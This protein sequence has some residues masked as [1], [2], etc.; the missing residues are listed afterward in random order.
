M[1]ERNFKG[2]VALI[3]GASSGIGKAIAQEFIRR[4]ATVIVHYHKDEKTAKGISQNI[5]QADLSKEEERL[6]LKIQ[7]QKITKHIDVLVNNAGFF[8]ETDGPNVS[9]KSLDKLF[10]VH[11]TAVIRLCS[12][13]HPLMNNNSNIIN[14]SSIHGIHSRPH[15]IGYSASKAATHSITVG[16]AQCYAPIRV[17]TVS[18][19]PVFTPMW[20]NTTKDIKVAGE[21]SLLKRFG[22]PEEIAKVVAFLAS[23]DASYITGTNIIVDGGTLSK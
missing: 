14:I 16:L 21:K 3:T 8:D 7:V 19:G 15:A 12:L 23:E 10:S 5:V 11:A 9:S 6:K 20:G 18:P 1:I 2:K 4:G 17:N 13:L 22:K